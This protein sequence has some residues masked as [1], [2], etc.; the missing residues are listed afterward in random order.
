MK[1]QIEKLKAREIPVFAH[2]TKLPYEKKA[3]SEMIGK[4]VTGWD[5]I[6]VIDDDLGY[7]VKVF[8]GYFEG[9]RWNTPWTDT[10]FDYKLNDDVQ[11]IW[12][13]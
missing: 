9:D 8:G 6:W 7:P 4:D 3:I 2:F 1:T 5:F 10:Q 11:V 12:E 13:K